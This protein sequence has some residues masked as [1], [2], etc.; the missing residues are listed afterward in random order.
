MENKEYRKH[1]ISE[2]KVEKVLGLKGEPE[3]DLLEETSTKQLRKI[4]RDN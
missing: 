1:E 2:R 3:V 4:M